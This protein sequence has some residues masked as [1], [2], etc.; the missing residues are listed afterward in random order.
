MGVELLDGL[1][2]KKQPLLRLEK[3]GFP[4]LAWLIRVEECTELCGHNPR[5]FQKEANLCASY[6]IVYMNEC[7]PS[8]IGRLSPRSVGAREKR[9]DEMHEWKPKNEWLSMRFV[10]VT[11]E[12]S[13]LCFVCTNC[14]R[15]A[16]HI[17]SP[18][19]GL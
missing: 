3:G 12:V 14:R 7:A 15:Y 18:A 4:N 19:S 1:A 8:P 6:C 2:I 9:K 5:S 13:S 17:L 16:Q 10:M 11:S